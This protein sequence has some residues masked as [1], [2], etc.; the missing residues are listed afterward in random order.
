MQKKWEEDFIEWLLGSI[1]LSLDA[2]VAKFGGKWY[3]AS[4]GVATGENFVYILPILLYSGLLMMLFIVGNTRIYSISTDLLMMA[5]EV[6]QERQYSFS[7]GFVM[8]I[9]Y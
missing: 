4:G 8:F 6:G 9:S 1:N 2:A 3:Q 7:V 5:Q